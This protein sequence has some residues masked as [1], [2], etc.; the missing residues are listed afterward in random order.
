M[1]G[2]AL[3]ATAAFVMVAMPAHAKGLLDQWLGQHHKDKPWHDQRYGQYW[4]QPQ[5]DPRF[6]RPNYGY[7]S[8]I[9]PSR[10]EFPGPQ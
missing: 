3:S 6:Q 8:P 2:S 4:R 5:H 1:R 7:S 9:P 10:S